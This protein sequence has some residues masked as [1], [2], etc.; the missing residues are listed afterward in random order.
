MVDS[1][2]LSPSAI[3]S[4]A[5]L[6]PLVALMSPLLCMGGLWLL[7]LDG[8]LEVT[9]A[10]CFAKWL[11]PLEVVH[12]PGDGWLVP[13][14][15]WKASLGE[16]ELG[17]GGMMRTAFMPAPAEQHTLVS[18]S[19][20][21]ARSNWPWWLQRSNP[22]SLDCAAT[23]QQGCCYLLIW[24]CWRVGCWNWSSPSIPRH[25]ALKTV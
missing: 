18:E 16:E 23:L 20:L 11:L 9:A 5:P 7:L 24:S 6:G 1:M 25:A 13:L 2:P 12:A 3:L 4:R 15:P 19:S 21:W 14:P 17:S 10:C 22:S 8:P